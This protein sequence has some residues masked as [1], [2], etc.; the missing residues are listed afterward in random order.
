MIPMYSL[1]Y[2]G[3]YFDTMADAIIRKAYVNLSG[4]YTMLDMYISEGVSTTGSV[5]S[6]TASSIT[7]EICS[8]AVPPKIAI[9]FGNIGSGA[10]APT[11]GY[12]M[13]GAT[14]IPLNMDFKIFKGVRDTT[15]NINTITKKFVYKYSSGS[16][17]SSYTWYMHGHLFYFA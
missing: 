15:L 8:L 12:Q 16:T 11:T 17:G 13:T 5:S 10:F 14:T 7:V 3:I 6:N 9:F 4:S 2:I 1:E